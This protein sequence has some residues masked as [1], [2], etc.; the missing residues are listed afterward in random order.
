MLHPIKQGYLEPLFA[1]HYV[2]PGSR[3]PQADI[4]ADQKY[5]SVGVK[6]YD[7]SGAEVVRAQGC[8]C[9]VPGSFAIYPKGHIPRYNNPYFV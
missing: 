7:V 6:G 8:V 9:E 4:Y 1:P 3:F 5:F 2:H